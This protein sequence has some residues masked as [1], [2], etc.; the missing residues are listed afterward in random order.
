[1]NCSKCGKSMKDKGSYWKCGDCGPD[2]VNKEG[3]MRYAEGYGV[4]PSELVE[5][6]E[7]DM[8]LETNA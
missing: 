6:V 8:D 4:T 2:K 7:E 3:C 1:M 5:M